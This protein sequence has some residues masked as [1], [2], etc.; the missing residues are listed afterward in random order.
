[1]IFSPFR[2]SFTSLNYLL[3]ILL[4]NFVRKNWLKKVSENSGF[5]LWDLVVRFGE[6]ER[7]W[8]I[9]IMNYLRVSLQLIGTLD[10]YIVVFSVFWPLTKSFSSPDTNCRCWNRNRGEI[11]FNHANLAHADFPRLKKS[12]SQGLGVN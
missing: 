5:V 2:T 12:T 4:F 3:N 10:R 9:S 7:L 11:D 6:Q 1:M 8:I